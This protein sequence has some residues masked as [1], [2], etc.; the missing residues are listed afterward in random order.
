MILTDPLMERLWRPGD[1]VR[2]AVEAVLVIAVIGAGRII[3]ARS[4]VG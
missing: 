4:H 3:T 2:Y 1:L